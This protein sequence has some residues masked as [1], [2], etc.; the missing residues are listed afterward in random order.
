MSADDGRPD[1]PTAPAAA[2]STIA[3]TA[4]TTAR[5]WAGAQIVRALIWHSFRSAFGIGRGAKA[6]IVPILA[7]RGH[8]ACPRS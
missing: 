4:A 7:V 1:H 5:G 2:S 6:K 8:A 3:A